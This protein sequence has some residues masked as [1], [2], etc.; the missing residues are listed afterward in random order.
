LF[1]APDDG[2]KSSSPPAPASAELIAA[3]GRAKDFHHA[4]EK[5]AA[6]GAWASKAYIFYST[7]HLTTQRINIG[8]REEQEWNTFDMFNHLQYGTARPAQWSGSGK[9]A[10]DE[11]EHWVDYEQWVVDDGRAYKKI[12]RL[13]ATRDT[14]G[15]GTVPLSSQLGF[16][17]PINVFRR[18]PG[19]PEHV[20]APNS[21]WLWERVIDVLLGYDVT[22]HLVPPSNQP[23][24]EPQT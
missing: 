10:D 12:W 21:E 1:H 22:K 4:S 11:K 2:G 7:G 13:S 9:N 19:S 3:A 16:G 18:L 23:H 14:N 5:I 8:L 6:S 24:K 20:P 15:D 17:G